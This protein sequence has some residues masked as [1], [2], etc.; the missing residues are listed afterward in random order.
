[1]KKHILYGAGLVTLALFLVFGVYYFV[2][3]E[4]KDYS[5]ASDSIEKIDTL[6]IQNDELRKQKKQLDIQ[7]E[8]I[9]KTLDANKKVIE[10]ESCKVEKRDVNATCEEGLK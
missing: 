7:K 5:W 1:M 6:T 10:I 8:E 3:A 9:N 2:V 4:G